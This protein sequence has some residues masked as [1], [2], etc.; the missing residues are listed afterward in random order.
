MRQSNQRKSQGKKLIS[1]KKKAK[2]SMVYGSSYTKFPSAINDRLKSSTH[3]KKQR[4]H[5]NNY[6]G[7]SREEKTINKDSSISFSNIPSNA[8]SSVAVHIKHSHT[9]SAFSTNK[10]ARRVCSTNL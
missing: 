4:S 5:L 7:N 10:M 3:H 8:S 9:N 6:M 1:F 2:N